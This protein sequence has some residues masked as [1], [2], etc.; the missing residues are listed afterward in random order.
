M[1]KRLILLIFSQVLLLSVK[2]QNFVFSQAAKPYTEIIGATSI[3][4]SKY[5]DTIPIGFDILVQGQKSNVIV[6][7]HFGGYFYFPNQLATQF[8]F[9]GTELTGG[10]FSY[11][12]E[13]ATGNRI[14]KL[15]A[16]NVGF[17]HDFTQQDYINAQVWIYEADNTIEVRYGKSYIQNWDFDFYFGLGGP[18]VGFTNLK[19]TGGAGLPV[20]TNVDTARITGAPANGKVY[21]FK[22][23]N[24]AI[25]EYERLDINVYPNPAKSYLVLTDEVKEAFLYSETGLRLQ[26]T[27]CK[28]GEE[29]IV[30]VSNVKQGV[31]WL[32]AIGANW[33]NEQKVLVE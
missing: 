6:V 8:A 24:V 1:K 17:G 23:Q 12:V 15:Q 31:Y 30:D 4:I 26:L 7:S 25:Q 2:A 28:Q 19:L 3:D 29:F 14:F 10:D 20:T 13:G 21:I 22:V 11:L 33:V 16:K 32:K 18:Q 27:V 9:F 5:T